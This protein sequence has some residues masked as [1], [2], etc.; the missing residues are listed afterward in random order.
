MFNFECQFM[1]QEILDNVTN[2]ETVISVEFVTRSTE[3]LFHPLSVR[4]AT[5]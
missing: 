2:S 5:D 4:I 1:V 3:N